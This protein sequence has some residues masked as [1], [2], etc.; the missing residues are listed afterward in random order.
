MVTKEGGMTAV[1]LA[2]GVAIT[3][4]LSVFMGAELQ[5]F[6]DRVYLDTAVAEVVGDLKYART[7][8]V[9]ERRIIQ[10]AIDQETPGVTVLRTGEPPQPV[11]PTRNLSGRGI[12]AIRSSGGSLLSFS[13]RGTS[14][15]PTTLTLEDR[16]GTQRVVTVSLIGISRTR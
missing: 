1:E 13:P 15:T 5:A 16:K 8:A 7:L 9:R 6:A 12:R 14:A 3:G 10:V 4:L 2:I 11:A